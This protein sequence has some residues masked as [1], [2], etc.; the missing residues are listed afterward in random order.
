MDL[1]SGVQMSN[2]LLKLHGVKCDEGAEI[3]A[4]L[5][6]SRVTEPLVLEEDGLIGAGEVTLRAVVGEVCP[7][8][9]LHVRLALEDGTAGVVTTL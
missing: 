5:V 1:L 8:M 4:Q 3:A 7:V 2:V 9:S 6:V